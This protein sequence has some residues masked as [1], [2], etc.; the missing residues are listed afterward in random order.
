MLCRFEI[1]DFR[2][3]QEQ[4]M[5]YI[6]KLMLFAKDLSVSIINIIKFFDAADPFIY[7]TKIN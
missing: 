1:N 2:Y 3:S 4:D 6:L 7:I 5:E